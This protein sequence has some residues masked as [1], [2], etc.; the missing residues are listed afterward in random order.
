MRSKHVEAVGLGQ[1]NRP[2]WGTFAHLPGMKVVVRPERS[3]PPWPI[4]DPTLLHAA[5]RRVA[6]PDVP[7]PRPARSDTR[8]F[9]APAGTI[10]A[11]SVS[12]GRHAVLVGVVAVTEARVTA[13]G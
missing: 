10:L 2:L 7:I 9:K 5:V 3:R 13:A 8:S 12:T 11:I 4:H 6:M 1:R